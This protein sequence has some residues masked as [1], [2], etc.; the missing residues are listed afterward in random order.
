MRSTLVTVGSSKLL[1]RKA[2]RLA[3]WRVTVKVLPVLHLN[4]TR[5]AAAVEV[6]SSAS[7]VSAYTHTHTHTHKLRRVVAWWTACGWC[8]I[9]WTEQLFF[10]V[11]L[12]WAFMAAVD[13]ATRT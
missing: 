1:L 9:G 3:A 13:L 2:E 7:M 12:V 4:W 11:I 6:S 8:Y 5:S 10:T